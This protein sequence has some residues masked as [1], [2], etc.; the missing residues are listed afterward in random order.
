M[1]ASGAACAANALEVGVFPLVAARAGLGAALAL[2]AALSAA[3]ALFA[4]AAV[5]ETRG[6]SPEHIYAML[7]AGK[8]RAEPEDD[9]PRSVSTHV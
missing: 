2:A 9:E 3:Y 8:R 1:L 4:L 6:L 7:A 5:P